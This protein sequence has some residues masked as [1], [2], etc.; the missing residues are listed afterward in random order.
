MKHFCTEIAPCE[1]L[2]FTYQLPKEVLICSPDCSDV[3]RRK[4]VASF[5]LL[6]ISVGEKRVEGKGDNEEN[7]SSK[8]FTK[9]LAFR[10]P[11]RWS[12]KGWQRM[13]KSRSVGMVAHQCSGWN[14]LQTTKG[15]A[16]NSHR[17]GFHFLCWVYLNNRATCFSDRSCLCYVPT[18]MLQR[19]DFSLIMLLSTP[20][21]SIRAEVSETQT[22]T[23]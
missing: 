9:H 14:S 18:W 11:H 10:Q 23:K 4:H 17:A 6:A 8:H 15:T 16:P 20:S 2:S 13:L 22:R 5:S 19:P 1:G 3:C 21:S 7:K 12:R